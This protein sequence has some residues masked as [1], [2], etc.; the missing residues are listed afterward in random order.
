MM[1]VTI[2][3]G[4]G[5]G[6]DSRILSVHLVDHFRQNGFEGR[7]RRVSIEKIGAEQAGRYFQRDQFDIEL[8]KFDD[9]KKARRLQRRG[10]NGFKVYAHGRYI[11]LIRSAASEAKLVKVFRSF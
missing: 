1:M 4:C 5:F 2:V 7:F 3:G 11:M 8:A 9:A 10:F 6:S